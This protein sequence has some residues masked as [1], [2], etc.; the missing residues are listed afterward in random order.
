MSNLSSE[1]LFHFTSSLDNLQ[2][3]LKDGIRYGV[4]AEKLPTR[5]LAYFVRGISFCN[6]PLS[7]I[8]DHVEWYGKYAIGLKR[9]VLRDIGASPV[10]YVHSQT[11]SLPQGS[12]AVDKYKTLPFLCFLKQYLGKQFNKSE[13]DY[14][15]KTFY[16]E[17]EWR[18]F[19]GKAE[20]AKY[21][22]LLELEEMRRNKEKKIP[23][24]PPLR[25]NVDM[26]EYIILEKPT[27]FATFDT[28]LKSHCAKERDSYLTKI[29]YYSQVRKDF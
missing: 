3:I 11:K 16:D 6:I 1:T 19:S 15:R 21:A 7:M 23:G 17:K 25:I 22:R 24:V 4:F 29:L 10:F 20:V 26:M 18:V 9:S 5:H 13:G 27:D 12:D 8:S 14:K 28:F 2:G